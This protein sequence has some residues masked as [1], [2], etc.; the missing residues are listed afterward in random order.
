MQEQDILLRLQDE[1]SKDIFL[2]R[3][4]Y[5]KNGEM[6]ELCRSLNATH[7]KYAGNPGLRDVF[8][9]KNDSDDGK[10]AGKKTIIYGAGDGG[11]LASFTLLMWNQEVECVCDADPN[12]RQ[13]GGMFGHSVIS[14][15]TLI[16]K[17]RDSVIIIAMLYKNV[18]D[19]VYDYLI[20]FGINRENIYC[21]Y[22]PCEAQYFGSS[23][24]I[25][26][27]NEVYVDAGAFDGD[28]CRAFLKWCD[29]NYKKI[30][31][32]EPDKPRF[33]L[34]S[35]EFS[36]NERIQCV[37]AGA[38]DTTG[39]VSF[40]TGDTGSSLIIGD[41]DDVIK[42]IEID[43]L[44]ATDDCV[45]LLKMDI[46]GAELKALKGSAQIIKR[47]KPRLAICVYHKAEDIIEIPQYILSLVPEYRFYLRHHKLI[48][49]SRRPQFETVLYALV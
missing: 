39:T 15:E 17:Y 12:K 32:L 22:H 38:Y 16:E 26:R 44:V 8:D 5:Y 21:L 25:P 42:T 14:P 34:I 46:E 1:W 9:Y 33:K 35:D 19:K 47:D 18:L 10:L 30:Y 36:S 2:A 31:L 45:T 20:S 29:K 48:N 43:N 23:F 28:S 4:N 24:M 7:R 13:H 41:G 40:S 37:E 6:T 3:L 11:F 27:E 49:A